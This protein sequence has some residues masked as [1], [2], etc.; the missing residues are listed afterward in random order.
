MASWEDK[1]GKNTWHARVST[2]STHMAQAHNLSLHSWK[3][4]NMAVQ[5]ETNLLI[6]SDVQSLVTSS[7]MNQSALVGLTNL[8]KIALSINVNL[9]LTCHDISAITSTKYA[10][11]IRPKYSYTFTLGS[12]KICSPIFTGYVG[13]RN[14]F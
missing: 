9:Q 6:W 4:F 8:S 3:Y 14:C 5:Q 1:T 11:K 10:C 2:C 12:C 13:R 7:R